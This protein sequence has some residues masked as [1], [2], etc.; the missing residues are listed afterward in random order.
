MAGDRNDGAF[1]LGVVL[2]AVA[3]G[4]AT[5]LLTPRSG[6]DLRDELAARARQMRA[7]FQERAATLPV[8]P[9]EAAGKVSAPADSERAAA[10]AAASPVADTTAVVETGSEPP[11]IVAEQATGDAEPA[12]EGQSSDA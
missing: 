5:L 11:V 12:R 1:I 9:W 2:G 7:R 4:I 10:V 8:R 6:D 3:G